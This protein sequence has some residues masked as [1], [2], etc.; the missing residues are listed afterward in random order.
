MVLIPNMAIHKQHEAQIWRLSTEEARVTVGNQSK[1]APLVTRF[2]ITFFNHASYV[3]CIYSK[4]D[5][6]DVPQHSQR[7]RKAYQRDNV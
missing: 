6:P 1:L 5:I 4:T 3:Q 7:L 2:T